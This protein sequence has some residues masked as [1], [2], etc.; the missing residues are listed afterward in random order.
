VAN[1]TRDEVML[2]RGRQESDTGEDWK[3][4]M[5]VDD[6]NIPHSFCIRTYYQEAQPPLIRANSWKLGKWIFLLLMIAR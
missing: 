3:P 5:I 4:V 6:E 1:S 2:A